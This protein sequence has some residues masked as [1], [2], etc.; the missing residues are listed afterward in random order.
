MRSARHRA[1][2]PCTKLRSSSTPTS[3][4]WDAPQL[5]RARAQALQLQP[6]DGAAAQVT[7]ATADAATA[8]QQLRAHVRDVVATELHGHASP[9]PSGVTMH[10]SADP[11]NWGAAH[12]TAPDLAEA[13]PPAVRAHVRFEKPGLF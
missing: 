9:L 5:C 10:L 8:P 1:R 4:S 12:A 13:L 7:I 2:A 11:C 6:F 3:P